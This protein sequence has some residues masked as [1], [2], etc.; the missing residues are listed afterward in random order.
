LINGSDLV[1]LECLMAVNPRTAH[2]TRFRPRLEALEERA[3]PAA[4]DLD[5]AFGQAGLASVAFAGTLQGGSVVAD[6]GGGLVLTGFNSSGSLVV[7]RVTRTGTLSSQ[8][9]SAG[10]TT[11]PA[12]FSE[13]G[14]VAVTP[15][16][17]IIVAG[18]NDVGDFAVVR[19]TAAGLLDTSFGRAGIATVAANLNGV[20]GIGLAPGNQLVV[21]GSTADG[22][23]QVIRLSRSG[24]LDARFGRG[25]TAIIDIPGTFIAS[26][27]RGVAVAATGHIVVAGT[28]TAGRNRPLGNFAVA[29]LTPAGRLDPTFGRRGISSFGNGANQAT[30]LAVLPNQQVVVVG[31]NRQDVAAARL[32]RAGR[33]DRTFSGD[34]FTTLLPG[35]GDSASEPT[36][37]PTLDGRL[38]IGSTVG[39]DRFVLGRLNR[40]GG[41]DTPFGT[42]GEVFVS[43]QPPAT[44]P[45]STPGAPSTPTANAALVSGGVFAL[46]TGTLLVGSLSTTTGNRV[47][48]TRLLNA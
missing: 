17:Q 39:A 27:N 40:S 16:R 44:S 21:A 24:Q 10:S 37:V 1:C 29:R 34:G 46:P 15:T 28:A 6:S 20:S 43:A 33:L 19:L 48:V 11:V 32:T 22:N 36:V 5:A 45:G 12:V 42:R 26:G 41:I 25:G 14:G 35:A 9:G 30:A 8:F 2:S 13:L 38:L 4:G 3:V 31:T 23:L 7:A 47:I 18:L